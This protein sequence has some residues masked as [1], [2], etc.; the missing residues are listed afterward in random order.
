[1]MLDTLSGVWR[2]MCLIK[3]DSDSLSLVLSLLREY[4]VT[5]NA[6][7]CEATSVS[8]DLSGQRN[9]GNRQCALLALRASLL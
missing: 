4:I 3:Y 8:W 5:N 2:D 7:L 6:E 9:V 1:M